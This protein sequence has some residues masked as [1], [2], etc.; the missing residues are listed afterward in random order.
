MEG[1]LFP[2]S[3]LG[4]P[5]YG[6]IKYKLGKPKAYVRSIAYG[7]EGIK[8]TLQQMAEAVKKY[9]I[10]LRPLAL[11]IVR[12]C[13]HKDYI[14]EA[15][16]IHEFVKNNVRWTRDIYKTETLQSPLRTLQWGAGDCD[17]I[18]IL[19]ASLFSSIGFPT[20]FVAVAANPEVPHLF[21]HVYTQ[22]QIGNV[23]YSSDASNP[24][25]PFGWETQ[26]VFRKMFWEID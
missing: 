17:D 14:C 21:S 19:T 13:P 23:W 2:F 7:D 5:S 22:V 10:Q 25:A 16:S 11:R 3:H 12:S 1:P 24:H 26:K 6:A 8:Q 20:R 18:A 9:R 15:R 4:E